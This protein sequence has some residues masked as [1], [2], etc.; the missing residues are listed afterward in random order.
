MPPGTGAITASRIPGNDTVQSGAML[1]GNMAATR[2][3]AAPAEKLF[4]QS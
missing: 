3:A 1:Q 2:A 4:V